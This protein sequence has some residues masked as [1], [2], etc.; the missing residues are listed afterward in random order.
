MVR[1]CYLEKLF[2][3]VEY[4]YDK[5]HFKGEGVDLFFSMNY[6][7]SPDH[8]ITLRAQGYLIFIKNWMLL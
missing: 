5:R 4:I 1:I 8:R 6:F 3:S 2:Q 7:M